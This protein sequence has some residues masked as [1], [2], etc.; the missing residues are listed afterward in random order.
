MRA[1]GVLYLTVVI[2]LLF[3]IGFL[4][5][6]LII[7]QPLSMDVFGRVSQ[8]FMGRDASGSPA[9]SGLLAGGMPAL[10]A[11]STARRSG[12][13]AGIASLFQ[14]KDL[15]DPRNLMALQLPYLPQKLPAAPVHAVPVAAVPP[16]QRSG[17]D[18]TVLDPPEVLMP[19]YIE[20]TLSEEI[21]IQIAHIELDEEPITLT[22]EGPQI[23]V[24]HSHSREAYMQD[25]A[26]PYKEAE[27]FRSNDLDHTVV[28][29]GEVLT[30]HLNRL[31]LPSLHDRTEHEQKNFAGS[32]ARSLETLKRQMA[33]HASL[34]IFLDIH[35]NAYERKNPDDEVII[36]N[37]ERVA[38]VFVVI[39]TGE[40]LLG[41]FEERPNWQENAKF[42]IKLTNKI[43]EL[44]P[45]LAKRVYYKNG[46]Y[47]QHVSTQ[48]ILIE[49][50]SN[51]T[52]QTEAKRATQYLAEALS[53]IVE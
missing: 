45:G 50:G 43:N 31:G 22:G 2:M 44:Y 15:R 25:P 28:K 37:G 47:N 18:R 46:R 27:A 42:A 30:E 24:Y 4:S 19:G 14:R 35:R 12:L 10:A 51:F 7:L 32:Y 39:G 11:D 13:L 20:E 5:Y 16:S 1:S 6:R 21:Q 52:T 29:V 23:L 26:N 17:G 34:Q 36:I 48:A 33:A 53:K 49:V 9:Y 8:G 38:K 40:G 3:A 41:G